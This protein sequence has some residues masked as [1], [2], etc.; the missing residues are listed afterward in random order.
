MKHRLKESSAFY[1]LPLF[2]TFKDEGTEGAS[3]FARN[4]G[5]LIV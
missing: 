2:L 1:L 3:G 4:H 5:C